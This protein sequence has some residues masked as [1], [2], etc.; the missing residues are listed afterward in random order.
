MSPRTASLS[1][2]ATGLRIGIAH[3]PRPAPVHGDAL[4]LQAALL[5][6]RTARP[7]SLL[8]RMVCAAWSW[9]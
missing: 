9:L 6:P 2:T 5:E 8:R 3:A 4:M 1:V 7:A